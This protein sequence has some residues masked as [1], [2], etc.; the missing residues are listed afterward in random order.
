[1]VTVRYYGFVRELTGC[2]EE[3]FTSA[4]LHVLL[5]ALEGKYGRE[6]RL[7]IERAQIFIN[8][9][10]VRD[11]RDIELAEGDV[12]SFVPAAAGG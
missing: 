1:M 3:H 2:R 6:T 9:D 8:E 7:R 5:R 4:S 11:G 12:L 10:L